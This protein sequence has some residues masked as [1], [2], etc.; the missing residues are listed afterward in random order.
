MDR[1]KKFLSAILRF[2]LGVA[3]EGGRVDRQREQA[4]RPQVISPFSRGMAT[5]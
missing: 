1:G 4:G 5:V 2:Y 3:C